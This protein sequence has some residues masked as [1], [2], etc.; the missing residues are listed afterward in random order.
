MNCNLVVAREGLGWDYNYN[1]DPLTCMLSSHLITLLIGQCTLVY[2]LCKYY[3][4]CPLKEY[5]SSIFSPPSFDNNTYIVTM[6]HL[7]Y[8]IYTSTL[9]PR[10]GAVLLGFP[11]GN[12][13]YPPTPLSQRSY[14]YK[15]PPQDRLNLDWI[16]DHT[17]YWI[18]WIGCEST[19]LG[20]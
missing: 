19:G 3:T 12:Y 1:Y 17:A 20:G 14:R 7:L 13:E 5:P 8:T 16:H 2:G 15:I 9:V 11:R 6:S 4:K 18:E 10:E